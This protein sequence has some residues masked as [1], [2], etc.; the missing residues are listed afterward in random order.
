MG[1][2]IIAVV[3]I[4]AGAGAIG[5]GVFKYLR[6]QKPNA[7]LR[8]DTTPPSLVYIDNIQVGQTPIEKI[9]KP[10]EIT[11]KLIP[12]STISA[13][14]TYQTKVHLTSQTITVIRRDFGDSDITSAGEVINL[15]PQPGKNA[16][17]AV[18]TSIPD[19]ASITLDGQPQGFTPILIPQV[20]AGDHQIVI[21]AP[22]FTPR[23]ISA[24]T[25]AGYKL[26]LNAKLAGL[27][28]EAPRSPGE[29]GAKEG[30]ATPSATLKK[31]YVEI[32]ATPT[33]FLR[34]REKPDTKSQ[35]LGRVQPG[36]R[37]PLLDKTTGW[38]LIKVDL[39][40]TA[41]GLPAGRQG[42]V[43]AQYVDKFE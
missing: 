27:P 16:S 11:I 28:S 42:W 19:S 26:N 20:Q 33:G 22:G 4:L 41:S 18:I 23:T 12:T 35:E 17:L 32:K 14:T 15:E 25:V 9:F 8:V 29:V 24:K 37:Y 36:D 1:K 13:L 30:D 5:F 38:Y 40:A 39:E 7:V 3:L 34:V 43:S 2:K 10:G 31:P 6:S 21:S